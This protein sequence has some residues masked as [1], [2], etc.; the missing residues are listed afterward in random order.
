[1]VVDSLYYIMDYECNYYRVNKENQLVVAKRAEE[2]TEFTFAQANS[3][4]C[5]GKK[6]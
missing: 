3:R 6:S 5:I 4:V 2:A 1:M